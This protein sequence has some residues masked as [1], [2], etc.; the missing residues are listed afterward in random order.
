MPSK[1]T[2]KPPSAG[3]AKAPGSSAPAAA[4]ASSPGSGSAAPPAAVDCKAHLR[5]LF[6]DGDL[7]SGAGLPEG[8]LLAD[9][10]AAFGDKHTDGRGRRGTFREYRVPQQEHT[11]RVFHQRDRVSLVDLGYPKLRQRPDA[12][13]AALGKPSAELVAHMGWQE[14]VYLD[15]GITIAI[16]EDGK[17]KQVSHLFAYV[18][19]TMD[20]YVDRLGGKDDWVRKFPRR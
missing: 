19:T 15:R 8:C 16:T 14:S 13:L 2:P 6:L 18:P 5:K 12:L 1:S 17:R 7:S 4:P 10:D 20:D 9:T 3:S 11:V